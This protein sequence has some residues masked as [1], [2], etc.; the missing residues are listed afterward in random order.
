MSGIPDIGKYSAPV[1]KDAVDHN[2][3]QLVFGGTL[4]KIGDEF[5]KRYE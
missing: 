1:S 3:A 2:A 5:A 4:A